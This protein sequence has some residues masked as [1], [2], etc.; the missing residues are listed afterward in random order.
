MQRH[1]SQ[2]QLAVDADVDRSYVGRLERGVENPIVGALEKL[3]EALS[4]NYRFFYAPRTGEPATEAIARRSRP[5]KPAKRRG[6]LR[7]SAQLRTQVIGRRSVVRAQ[8]FLQ[9]ST[10]PSKLVEI[11]FAAWL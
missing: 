4:A 6:N 5:A 7:S 8:P 9:P 3:V 11:F 2:E 1:F 10:I